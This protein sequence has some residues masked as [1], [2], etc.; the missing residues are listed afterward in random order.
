MSETFRVG[1]WVVFKNERGELMPSIGAREVTSSDLSF[2]M[3]GDWKFNAGTQKLVRESGYA[4]YP[5]AIDAIAHPSQSDVAACQKYDA[6]SA[7]FG[8]LVDFMEIANNLQ[9]GQ[10]TAAQTAKL[11]AAISDQQCLCPTCNWWRPPFAHGPGNCHNANLIAITRA[12]DD[13]FP[14]PTPATFGCVHWEPK[15]LTEETEPND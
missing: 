6:E 3:I 8:E 13:G 1:D 7:A 2:V 4:G 11:R 10:I 15:E 5:G 14:P 12:G 9:P